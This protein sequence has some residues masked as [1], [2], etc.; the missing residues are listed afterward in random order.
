CPPKDP[1][2]LARLQACVDVVFGTHRPDREERILRTHAAEDLQWVRSLGVDESSARR[3]YT[4]ILLKAARM[5]PDRVV[6]CGEGGY[7]LEVLLE[8]QWLSFEDALTRSAAP[9]P[10]RSPKRE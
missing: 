7:R 4:R 6:P 3:L 8:G 5:L 2:R 9:L 1:A 10:A